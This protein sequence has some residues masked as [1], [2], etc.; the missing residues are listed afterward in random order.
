MSRSNID[1]ER[2]RLLVT[3][4]ESRSQHDRNRV[5]ESFM[6]LADYFARRYFDRPVEPEDLRQ[7]A[8][9]GLIKSVDRFDPDNGASFATFAGRTIDGELKHWLR[10]R[11]APIRLPRSIKESTAAVAAARRVLEQRHGRPPTVP[12]LAEHAGLEV[13]IVIEAL[14]AAANTTP[15]RL[16]GPFGE[17]G[18]LHETL[19][20]QDSGFSQ[21]E[22]ELVIAQ[23]L[24]NVS[25][26]ESEIIQLRFF[27]QLSQQEIA[28]RVGVSQMQVS[29]LL[30]STLTALQKRGSAED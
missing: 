29:R 23:L 6:P 17:E 4:A 28:D 11:T 21:S 9:M 8:R 7:V 14:D 2:H 30:R 3:F 13:D 10:D 16:D 18:E 25:P 24:Q 15:L 20:T 5:V 19:A 22:L 12:E 26:Q 27:E 1:E